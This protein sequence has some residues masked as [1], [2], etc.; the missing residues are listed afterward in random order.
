MKKTAT[1][2]PKHA[3]GI[4]DNHC[5]GNVGDYLRAR[6][7]DGADLSFVSAFF[8]IYAYEALKKELDR[9]T[10]LRFL[11]GEPRFVQSLDP[12]KTQMKAFRIEEDKLAIANRLQQ[13]RVA[14]DCADWIEARV[15]I[16]SVKQSGF[17]HGKMYHMANGGVQE[18]IIGSS[19]FTV[20]GLGLAQAG[21]NIELNLEV[22]DNRDRNDLKA[23]FDELWCDEALVAGLIEESEKLTPRGRTKVIRLTELSKRFLED[24]ASGLQKK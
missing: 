13:K 21:N 3:T 17:L 1:P 10:L 19:N 7:H 22:N 20:R 6:I 11:F 23:W 15:E 4:W 9:I 2:E 16:K 5:R 8:T 12:D 14:K 18:A 24:L